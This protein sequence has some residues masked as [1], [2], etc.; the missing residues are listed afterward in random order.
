MNIEYQLSDTVIHGYI[1]DC[2]AD[3]VDTVTNKEVDIS[4]NAIRMFTKSNKKPSI[5][6]LSRVAHNCEKVL[7]KIYYLES[8]D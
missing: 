7:K 8:K 2:F 6:T 5:K 4:E 1:C 3:P